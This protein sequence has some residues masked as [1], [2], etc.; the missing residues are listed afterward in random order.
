MKLLTRKFGEIEVD[1]EKIITMPAGMLGF[2]DRTRY[3]LFEREESRPFCWYQ[4]VDDTDLAFLVINPFLF[5]PDYAVDLSPAVREMG[6]AEKNREELILYVVVD[7]S[8]GGIENITANLIGPI[9]INPATRESIQ[10]VISDSPYSCQ[11][12]IFPEDQKVG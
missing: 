4:S 3:V 12:P 7:T 11:Q 5:K 10:M 9:V 8:S 2:T 1:E 6:W